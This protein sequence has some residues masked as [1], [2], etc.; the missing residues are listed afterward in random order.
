MG[1]SFE[2]LCADSGSHARLGVLGTP[3]GQIS[4]PAF[5]P[6]GTQGTVK[7]VDP[8]D[9]RELGAEHCYVGTGI[10]MAANRFYDSVGFKVIHTGHMWEKEF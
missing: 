2:I 5:A 4:T 10:G 3:H 8:R 6:V 9:L 1:F 7:A